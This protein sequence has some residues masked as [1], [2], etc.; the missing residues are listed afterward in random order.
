MEAINDTIL[1]EITQ[2]I[3]SRLLPF[4]ENFRLLRN[5]KEDIPGVLQIG[6]TWSS[7][8]DYLLSLWKWLQAAIGNDKSA[9]ENGHRRIDLLKFY[10][11]IMPLLEV[12]NAI[13]E[14]NKTVKLTGNQQQKSLAE[15][16]LSVSPK[17]VIQE[18]CRSFTWEYCRMEIWDWLDGAIS[19]DEF[20]KVGLERS[21]LLLEYQ[22]IHGLIEAAYLLDS[23]NEE[24]ILC[25]SKEEIKSEKN[26]MV[27]IKYYFLNNPLEQAKAMMQEF[28]S[29]WVHHTAE[30][31]AAKEHS[32][33]LM[34]HDYV[35]QLFDE[36]HNVVKEPVEDEKA[37]PNI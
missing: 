19:N 23:E 7:L 8:D 25:N 32:E 24:K 17:V 15:S 22:C 26:E 20:Y 34:F 3:K 16:N 13:N 30:V 10:D 12:L 2:P 35:V 33:K 18:F 9:Y 37:Q 14:T 27:A 36:L 4:D 6:F 1:Q 31:A 29:A 11:S 5:V 21:F 28:Y